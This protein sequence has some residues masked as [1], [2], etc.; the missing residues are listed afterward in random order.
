[1]TAMQTRWPTFADSD[2]CP[3]GSGRDFAHCCAPLIQGAPAPTAESLMRSRYTAFVVGDRDYLQ[4]TWHSRHRPATLELSPARE[5]RRLRVLETSAGGAQDSEGEVR[6]VAYFREPDGRRD[7][8]REHSRF[9]RED[10]K[11]RYLD[12]R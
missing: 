5:W 10:G 3:C 12:A 6:F 7:Q 9:V 1:M 4:R 2:P 8:L 11:W